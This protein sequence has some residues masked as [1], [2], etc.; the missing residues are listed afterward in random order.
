MKVLALKTFVIDADAILLDIPNQHGAVECCNRSG[1]I[2][3]TE[4]TDAATWIDGRKCLRAGIEHTLP[5]LGISEDSIGIDD[6]SV[7]SLD[8]AAEPKAGM[9][10]RC[11]I[12]WYH[13][14]TGAVGFINHPLEILEQ[15]LIGANW[16]SGNDCVGLNETL[17]LV[18]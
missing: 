12:T 11:E 5:A 10:S 18:F 1:K 4:Y 8:P 13:T 14:V 3:V 15:G 7:H 16:T 9:N 2:T 17:F 6:L